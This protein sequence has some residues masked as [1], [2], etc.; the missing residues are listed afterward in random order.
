MAFTAP[1]TS[2]DE[3]QYTDTPYPQSHPGHLAVVA[4]LAGLATAPVGRCRVLE[5]GCARGGNLIPMAVGL[6]GSSFLGIDASASQVAAGCS[7]I[8]A[9]GLKNVAIE[10]RDILDVGDELG[11]FDYIIC[12]GIYS[13]V[14]AEVRDR[15]LEILSRNLAPHGVAYLSYNT[16]PGWRLRGLVRDLMGLHAGRQED[17]GDRAREARRVLEFMAAAAPL[18]DRTYAAMLGQECER[19]R[20]RTDSYLLHEYFDEVNEPLYFHEMVRR[21]SAKGLRFI[22]EVQGGLLD[23]DTLYP[24]IAAEL[25]TLAAAEVDFEQYLDFLIDRTFRQRVFCHAGR[26][27]SRPPRAE[28]LSGLDVA[29]PSSGTLPRVAFRNERLLLAALGCV[30]D[31]RPGAMPWFSLMRAARSRIGPDV[32]GADEVRDSEDLTSDLLRC[33]RLKAIEFRPRDWTFATRAG[34]R[35]MASPLARYQAGLG[36]IV[37]NLRH[38]PTRLNEFSRAVLPLLDGSRDRAALLGALRSSSPG[39]DEANLPAMLEQ[40]LERLAGFALLMP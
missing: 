24:A 35:P 17:P 19:L 31:A 26:E 9:L 10:P 21:A 13:W 33:Y 23:V 38:E 29:A 8:A 11:L 15:I 30:A 34:E 5:I 14:P 4:T 28:D 1:A 6:P 27:M 32:G 16:E 40:S 18:F 37:T 22:S 3:V 25:R 7:V 36:D 12:H 20:R 39:T 2:Y